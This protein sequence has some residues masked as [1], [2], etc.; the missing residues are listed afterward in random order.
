MLLWTCDFIYM[1]LLVSMWS[2]IQS[3]APPDPTGPLSFRSSSSGKQITTQYVVACRGLVSCFCPLPLPCLPFS[4]PVPDQPFK[5]GPKKFWS[6]LRFLPFKRLFFPCH[7]CSWGS[8]SWLPHLEI[9][10]DCN[11]GSYIY[12]VFTS[13]M[14]KLHGWC[15]LIHICQGNCADPQRMQ[16]KC[17][18]LRKKTTDVLIRTYP[19]I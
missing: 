8:D 9:I 4:S 16:L 11:R 14:E 10:F 19:G 17:M 5:G 15:W 1:A 18:T 12:I 3:T 13:R 2:L 7:C 6:C